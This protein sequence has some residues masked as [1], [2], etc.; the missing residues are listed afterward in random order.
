MKGMP[1][2]QEGDHRGRLKLPGERGGERCFPLSGAWL[3]WP[4]L[5][6]KLFLKILKTLKPK[7]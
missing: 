5:I 6:E 2:D 1:D 4:K 7:D 3:L